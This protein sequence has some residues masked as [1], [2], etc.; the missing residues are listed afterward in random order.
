MMRNLLILI[1]VVAALA[2]LRWLVRDVARAV[3]GVLR[4]GGSGDQAATG[5]GKTA[6]NRLVKDPL[7]GTYIDERFAVKD[8]IDGENVFFE[9]KENRDAYRRQRRSG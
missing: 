4:G 1:L 8:V 2:L 6:T 3:M 7:S 9:S 5:S